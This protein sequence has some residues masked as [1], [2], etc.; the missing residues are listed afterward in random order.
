LNK[1]IIFF[2]RRESQENRKHEKD[3]KWRRFS[4]IEMEKAIRQETECCFR[5]S[6]WFWV[7]SKETNI[8]LNNHKELNST[9]TLNELG[10]K[11]IPQN[12]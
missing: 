7:S 11:F 3:L 10:N 4:I 5:R 9:N 6:E 2:C 1:N 12:L 8:S